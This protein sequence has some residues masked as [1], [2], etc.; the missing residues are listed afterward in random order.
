MCHKRGRDKCVGISE[1]KGITQPGAN[2]GRLIKQI[3][4]RSLQEWAGS[5][6]AELIK[7]TF[8]SAA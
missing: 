6:Y 8:I 4:R 1:H 5:I 2:L 7:I 3:F